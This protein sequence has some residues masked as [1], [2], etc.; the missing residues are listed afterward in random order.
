MKINRRVVWSEGMFM[1]PQHMQV[2]D[3]FHEAQLDARLAA[4]AGDA[5]GVAA[6]EIDA[7]AL[8]LGELR[9]LRFAGVMP[10]GLV[11]QFEAEDAPPARAVKGHLA[12]TATSVDVYLAVPRE[13]E[14]VPGYDGPGVGAARR[15][16]WSRVPRMV[17]DRVAGASEVELEVAA[18]R[19]ELLFG[20]EGRGEHEVIKVAEVERNAA[21]SLVLVAGFVPPVL[22]VG[23]SPWLTA[24]LGKLL[25]LMVA[26]QRR[27]AE[28]CRQRD[29][30]S[31]EFMGSDVTRF[32]LL[33][34]VNAK[35]PTLRYVVET[36][37]LSPRA[38]YLQ[39]IELAGALGTF[40]PEGALGQVANFSYLDLRA[41]FGELLRQ[42]TGLLGA[43]A[44]ES[45]LRVA[46]ERRPDG[47]FV[48]KLQD[49]RV[50]ASKRY[51][52]A[53]RAELPEAQLAEQLPRLAKIA[54]VADIHQ[55]VQAALPGVP[56][57][58]TYRPPAQIAVRS[59]VVY[60]AL[61][62]S[63]ATWRSVVYE[64]SIAIYLPPTL[65]GRELAVELLV[66]PEG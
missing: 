18:P 40:S 10:D 51:Y 15:P 3:A 24:E 48:G 25:T 4:L 17:L 61:D 22:R 54:T 53:V 35:V 14:G 47:T 60:F 46:L 20:D 7:S 58:V 65:G 33:S 59:G 16:R 31:V 62:T 1:A 13:R 39:L 5:W 32:L 9:L 49:E 36:G 52:L 34:A 37:E 64:R 63:H 30:A 66:I 50:L 12:P 56:V 28:A 42:I 8:S 43:A 38:L 57:Q 11:A 19:L 55:F 41:T 26:R 45:D 29:G 6:L 21:G 23:A 27:L 44:F 2:L